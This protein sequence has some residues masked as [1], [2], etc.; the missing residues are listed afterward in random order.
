MKQLFFFLFGIA[1]LI[2]CS[3]NAQ[4]TNLSVNEFEKQISP[5]KQLLDVRTADEY[6]S[7][8]IAKALQADWKNQAEFTER[9]KSLDKNKTVLIYCLGGGRSKAAAAW[10][11]ENGF[12]NVLELDGGM[13]A[14]KQNNKP[15]EGATNT[16]QMTLAD[17]SAKINSKLVLVDFGAE[18]CPPCKKMEPVLAQLQTDLK[19]KFKMVKVDG[20]NDTDVM[21]Q[22]G[23]TALPVFIIYKNGKQVWRK[24]GI[25]SYEDL[26]KAISSE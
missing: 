22:E 25:V 11:R 7:G 18:W 6:K 1:F 15:V 13:N 14:W 23:V 20:G 9:T 10:M 12:T 5:D 19:G 4:S 16:P 3:S 17:Y 26:K 8:H 2:S 24:D 21:K